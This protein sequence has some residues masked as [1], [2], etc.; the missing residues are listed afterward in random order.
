MLL[1]S[2]HLK[3]NNIVKEALCERKSGRKTIFSNLLK[4]SVGDVLI[5]FF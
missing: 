5:V 2:D 1:F 3:Y 4:F